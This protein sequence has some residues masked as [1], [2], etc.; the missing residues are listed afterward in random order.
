MR[1]K[2]PNWRDAAFQAA[3][4]EHICAQVG[5]ADDLFVSAEALSYIRHPDEVEALQSLLGSRDVTFVV[6]LRD[7]RDYLR[8]YRAQLIE[9]G[10]A[11][12][13]DPRSFAYSEPDSWLADYDALT[14][15]LGRP[16]VVEYPSN[17]SVIPALFG[18]LGFDEAELP[19]W[20]NVW[21]NATTHSPRRRLAGLLRRSGRRAGGLIP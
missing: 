12:S 4:R 2:M 19:D 21:R 16:I 5:G 15:V 6:V 17:R 9:S 11:P 3:M 20:S 18:A 13:N 14:S 10:F 8:S 7:R 1:S